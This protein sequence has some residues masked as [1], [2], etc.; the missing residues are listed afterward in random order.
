MKTV[1]N[2]RVLITGAGGDGIGNALAHAFAKRGAHI[3]ICDIKNLEKTI[4]ELDEYD[5][6]SYAEKVDVGNKKEITRFLENVAQYFGPID[7]LINN[8]G[9]ALGGLAFENVSQ[10]DFERITNINYWGVIHTTQILFPTLIKRPEAA[11][12]NI[13]SSQGI[14]GV[15]NLVPYC[16]TKFAVRGFTDALR[17]EMQMRNIHHLTVHTVHPGAVATNITLNADYKGSHTEPFHEMLQKKGASPNQAAEIILKG[18]LKNKSRIFI[19]D[20]R[21]QDIIARLFPSSYYKVI[22]WL[23]KRRNLHISED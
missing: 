1:K 16:T 20:G 11:I 14:V 19:S 10:A 7:I 2:K 9:I 6:E 22:R 23:M 8:A 13:S 17:V 3:A 12:V 18:V 15:S 4:N 21:A 5:I